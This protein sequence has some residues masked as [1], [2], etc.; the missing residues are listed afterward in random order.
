MKRSAISISAV[1]LLLL[2]GFYLHAPVAAQKDKKTIQLGPLVTRTTTRH[3]SRRL[4]YGGAVT[5]VGAPA[6][7]I[8]IEGW[9]RSE[10]DISAEVELRAPSQQDLDLLAAVD[11]FL[12]DEDANH[13]RIIAIGTHDK[14]FMK[15]AK[16][17]P[18]YLI[19]LPWK[20][21]YRLK[22]P[23]MCDLA[24][25]T[26]NGPIKL[27]GVEG[28]IRINALESDADLALT[29]SDVAVI[30]QKG[31]VNFS[32]PARAWHGL[33]A[34]IKLASGNLNVDLMPG[35]NGDINAE[36]LRT[37]EVK[38]LFSGLE[39]RERNSIGPRS[40]RARAGS[41][42]AMLTFTVGDGTIQMGSVGLKQ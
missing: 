31:T 40:V 30:I 35:F 26:G 10:V 6:G 33:R 19:G 11:T 27:S 15:Q 17:F 22:V 9:Q 18:K 12:I 32:I 28:S 23:A 3:D 16:N 5:I 13:I 34:E 21:D 38:N 42:G 7:S 29:G 24:I 4:G 39:P 20:V 25:D 2:S 14:K 41:G 8:T 1:A 37:G 36:V